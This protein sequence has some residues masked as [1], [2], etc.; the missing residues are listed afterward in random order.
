MKLSRLLIAAVVLAGL[1]AALWWSNKKED[2]KAK[3]PVEDKTL[4]D[5]LA[6]GRRNLR[7]R[8]QKAIG[9][10]YCS[11]EERFRRLV[12]HRA[13]TIAG[14]SVL[15]RKHCERGERPQCRPRGRRQRHRP[16]VLRPRAGRRRNLSRL[17][18]FGGPFGY[19]CSLALVRRFGDG[20]HIIR[21]RISSLGSDS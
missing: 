20:P 17:L 1:A 21:D 4:E 15:G 16:S 8:N 9:R 2:E 13:E 7:H 14:G 10:G 12:N 3:T 18:S 11:V 5:P 6:Q 19:W